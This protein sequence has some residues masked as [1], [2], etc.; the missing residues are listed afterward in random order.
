MRT[1]ELPRGV[2]PG[3]ATS[4]TRGDLAIEMGSVTGVSATGRYKAFAA[5]FANRPLVVVTGIRS[6]GSVTPALYGTP[7]VGSFRVRMQAVGST[8]LQYIAMGAR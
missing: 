2:V 8:M 4:T 6:A 1:N 5:T 7:A 3:L